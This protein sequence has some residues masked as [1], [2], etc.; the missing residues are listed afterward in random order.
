MSHQMN[1]VVIEQRCRMPSGTSDSCD[2]EVLVDSSGERCLG[3]EAAQ[4]LSIVDWLHKEGGARDVQ[5]QTKGSRSQEVAL[6][7]AALDPAAFSSLSTEGACTASPGCWRS[8]FLSA[9]HRFVLPRTSIST[10][11]S[12]RSARSL[13]R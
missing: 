5:V 6:I 4:L 1:V 2:W 10:S 8:R 12:I 7:A 13:L 9:P 11:T 3:M